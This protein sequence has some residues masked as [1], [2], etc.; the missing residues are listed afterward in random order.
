MG[1]EDRIEFWIGF[2]VE[3]MDVRA[4]HLPIPKIYVEIL[5]FTWVVIPIIKPKWILI[6]SIVLIFFREF[7]LMVFNPDERSFSSNHDTN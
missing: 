2:V 1:D 7:Q 6:S 4:S 5:V 3:Y